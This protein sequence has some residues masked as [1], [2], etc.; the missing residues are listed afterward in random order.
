MGYKPLLKWDA[1]PSAT[2]TTI[3]GIIRV[4]PRS[5]SFVTQP[6]C[7]RQELETCK[8]QAAQAASDF[9]ERRS[10]N[11]FEGV[12]RPEN[13]G[14]HL[15]VTQIPSVWGWFSIVCIAFWPRFRCS[16]VMSNR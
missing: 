11:I 3:I 16:Q 14:K 9:K 5:V 6:P 4:S 13:C 10:V 7:P 2:A 8:A 1:H 15:K 12:G